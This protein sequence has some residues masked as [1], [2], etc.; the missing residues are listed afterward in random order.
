MPEAQCVRGKE[1]KKVMLLQLSPT[2]FEVVADVLRRA[3]GDL[4]EE[5]YKTEEAQFEAK[6]KQREA[7]LNGVLMRM[8]TADGSGLVAGEPAAARH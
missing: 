5:I 6:L 2:E 3:M 7:V 4:R 1:V 8:A